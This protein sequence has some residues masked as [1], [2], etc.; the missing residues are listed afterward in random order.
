M[1]GADACT[2][3]LGE[4][5]M[6]S[7]RRRVPRVWDSYTKDMRPT[8]VTI[9]LTRKYSS[10]ESNRRKLYQMI[11]QSAS[12]LVSQNKPVGKPQTEPKES[13]Q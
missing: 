11:S 6:L 5:Y 12:Q 13:C 7:N 8:A 2:L 1:N 10:T 4:H 9:K 3:V